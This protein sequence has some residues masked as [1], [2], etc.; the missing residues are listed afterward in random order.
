LDKSSVQSIG[1]SAIVLS[2][3]DG[4]EG[5]CPGMTV[6]ISVFEQLPVVGIGQKGFDIRARLFL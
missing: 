2:G 4:L 6:R 1:G 3:P 5:R